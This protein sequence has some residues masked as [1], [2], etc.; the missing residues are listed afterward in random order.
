[1]SYTTPTVILTSLGVIAGIGYYNLVA[2]EP[3]APS[4]SVL[5]KVAATVAPDFSVLPS[6]YLLTGCTMPSTSP[7]PGFQPP[8]GFCLTPDPRAAAIPPS[9][10]AALAPP[11]Y[12]WTDAIR[13]VIVGEATG[14]LTDL[15]AE[16]LNPVF[17]D[18]FGTQVGGYVTNGV[19][20]VISGL[21]YGGEFGDIALG[22]L[23]DTAKQVA[24]DELDNTPTGA[25]IAAGAKTGE[26]AY[27]IAQYFAACSQN[28]PSCFSG[29][30]TQVRSLIGLADTWSEAIA[31]LEPLPSVE[32]DGLEIGAGDLLD[33]RLQGL[34]TVGALGAALTPKLEAFIRDAE[35]R[36]YVIPQDCVG[37]LTCRSDAAIVLA[38]FED[39]ANQPITTNV[40]DGLAG[41]ASGQCRSML[42][43]VRGL[44]AREDGRPS[45]LS[46]SPLTAYQFGDYVDTLQKLTALGK[47]TDPRV[48]EALNNLGTL[49]A[50]PPASTLGGNWK[51]CVGDPSRMCLDITD[52]TKVVRM[53]TDAEIDSLVEQ[54]DYAAKIGDPNLV[55]RINTLY[56]GDT[57]V[58]KIERVPNSNGTAVAVHLTNGSV[59]IYITGWTDNDKNTGGFGG[60][61][62]AVVAD[63]DG[64]L[65]AV[66]LPRRGTPQDPTG[67][68]IAQLIYGS[69]DKGLEYRYA[70]ITAYL[71]RY[72][73]PNTEIIGHSLGGGAA[74]K[75]CA[76][77]WA[78]HCS[79]IAPPYKFI[80]DYRQCGPDKCAVY[81]GDRDFIINLQTGGSAER[82][83]ADYVEDPAN[84]VQMVPQGVGGADAHKLS[85]YC[86]HVDR[87]GNAYF[88]EVPCWGIE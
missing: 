10:A 28:T 66:L 2:Q 88:F 60:Y 63:S 36:G 41:P 13:D 23:K 70:A 57:S 78:S 31:N 8:A 75:L 48:V 6:G 11:T 84:R 4:S 74:L 73:K 12:G 49:T 50:G 83:W 38:G 29:A 37:S 3:D 35:D 82:T 42:R 33:T 15:A 26:A 80:Y 24:Y 55:V 45:P 64:R 40:C 62:D 27:S 16:Q 5:Q 34:A 68:S 61:I 52:P 46:T 53:L 67:E 71:K 44:V 65:G 9:S 17:S 39:I 72:G 86:T 14:G 59:R 25:V 87:N 79:A 56:R 19:I 22:V 43:A 76:N 21:A 47:I 81:V 30:P 58:K 51:P 85:A 69:M 18:V 7:V 20:S 54:L 32:V 1:M 77:G